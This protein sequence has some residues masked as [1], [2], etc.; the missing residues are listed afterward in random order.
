MITDENVLKIAE[1]IENANNI[2]ITCLLF[3]YS[4]GP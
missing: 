2:D 4:A 1:R 3:I